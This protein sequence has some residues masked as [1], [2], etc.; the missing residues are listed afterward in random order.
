MRYILMQIECQQV[1]ISVEH[2][3]KRIRLI[4]KNGLTTTNCYNYHI[5]M[6]IVGLSGNKRA[7]ELSKKFQNL[8]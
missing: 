7:A 5:T 3:N 2:M 4:S 8:L 1:A 6:E